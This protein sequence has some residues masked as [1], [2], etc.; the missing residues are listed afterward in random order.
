MLLGCVSGYNWEYRSRFAFYQDE[1]VMDLLMRGVEYWM[2]MKDTF[3]V[4][5]LTT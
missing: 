4:C 3:E 5:P 2:S 1:E